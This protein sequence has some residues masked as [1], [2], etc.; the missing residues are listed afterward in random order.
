MSTGPGCCLP[1][2]D[3]NGIHLTAADS[4]ADRLSSTGCSSA[5]STVAVWQYCTV[6]R[7]TETRNCWSACAPAGAVRPAAGCSQRCS[8]NWRRLLMYCGYQSLIHDGPVEEEE[9]KWLEIETH[10]GRC[11]KR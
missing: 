7:S 11:F 5:G 2:D 9:S 8:A 10:N 3:A 6:A 4:P 1:G